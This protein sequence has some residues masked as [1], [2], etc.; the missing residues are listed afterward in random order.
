MDTTIKPQQ[1]KQH[2]VGAKTDI[3]VNGTERTSPKEI[4]LSAVTESSAKEAGIHV[5]K[6]KVSSASS[7]GKVG[8][9]YINK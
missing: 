3:W 6:T 5:G 7:I 2:G 4:H 1:P 8:Q 9:L